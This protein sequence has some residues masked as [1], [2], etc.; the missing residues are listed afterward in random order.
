MRCLI[1]VILTLSAGISLAPVVPGTPRRVRDIFPNHVGDRWTYANAGRKEFGDQVNWLIV[2]VIGSLRLPNGK[3]ANIW[4]YKFPRGTDTT[5]VLSSGTKATV[6]FGNIAT[7]PRDPGEMPME[8]WSYHFPLSA[9]D[10]WV[11]DYPHGDTVKVQPRQEVLV[12]AGRFSNSYLLVNYTDQSVEI[13][14][15]R[16]VDSVWFTPGIGVTR[17]V[18]N[19][20]NVRPALGN[21]NWELLNYQ[22]K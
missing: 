16:K 11:L 14:N 12:P 2:E 5:Y 8:K 21:G 18:Q 22:F 9:S 10:F 4:L 13:R 1:S 7:H 6:Y 3:I 20:F 17:F 19:E 15:F